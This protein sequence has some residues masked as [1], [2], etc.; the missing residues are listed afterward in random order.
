MDEK[1][2]LKGIKQD[3]EVRVMKKESL[4]LVVEKRRKSEEE[5]EEYIWGKR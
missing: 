2:L 4:G 1:S 5:L 3:P